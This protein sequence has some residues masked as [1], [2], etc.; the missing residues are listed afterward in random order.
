MSVARYYYVCG[1]AFNGIFSLHAEEELRLKR[2]I[3]KI[4]TKLSKSGVTQ[5]LGW[6]TE[7]L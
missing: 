6:S 3:N 7:D 5:V 2:G 1:V 4:I